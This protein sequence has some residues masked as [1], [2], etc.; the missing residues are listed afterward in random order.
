[1]S[2]FA[3]QAFS[4]WLSGKL[5]NPFSDWEVR[6]P[7][8][9]EWE[10]AAKSSL[11]PDGRNGIF[12]PDNT[13]EWCADPYSPLPFLS[14]PPEAAAGVGSPEYS[15]RGGSWMNAA[16][17]IS[18]ETRAALPPATCSSFVSFRPVIA[19]KSGGTSV[20]R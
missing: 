19:R 8:E 10:Y 5:P 4:R 17:K 1:V 12:A 15:L 7:T 9:T 14:A 18:Y 13:W 6:L 11:K 2:W 3:A 20:S 16:A